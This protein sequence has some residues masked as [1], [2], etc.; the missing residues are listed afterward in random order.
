MKMEWSLYPASEFEQ[1][2]KSW[3]AL[4]ACGF[5]SPLLSSRFLISCLNSFGSG[6]EVLCLLGNPNQPDAMCILVR[7]GKLKWDTFQPSQAPIGF[8]L[9]RPGLELETVLR[10]LMIALPGFALSLGL[11]QQDPLLLPRPV[12]SDRML[13]FDYIVTA[14]IELD[15]DYEA[16]WQ[17]RGK[18]LRQNMRTVRNRLEKQS[19]VHQLKCITD[20][21]EVS[22][23]VEHFARM[24]GAGWKSE[25]GTAVQFDG[26]QGRFYV[27]LLERFCASD[28]ACIYCLTFNE[29]IVAMDLCVHQDGSVIVLKT[30]YDES[31]HD[32]SPAML[33]HQEML[34]MLMGSPDFHRLEFYGKV[35]DW[36]LRLTEK[37][38]CMYHVNVY[39]WAWLRRVMGKRIALSSRS[40]GVA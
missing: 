22:K 10:A 29:V 15:E 11:T 33:L 6:K 13:A 5:N 7:H 26:R 27:K 21:A 2:V 18:N 24:E 36:Q 19:Q 17:T 40:G 28:A 35:R 37:T 30:T 9:M 23:A 32:Y 4:N 12:G 14:H 20:C 25:Q 8:W 31:Y 16:Y 39:R 3:D 38:R 1:H 34:R